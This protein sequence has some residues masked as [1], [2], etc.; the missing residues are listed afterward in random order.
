MGF[1]EITAR[2]FPGKRLDPK[3]EGIKATV[4]IGVLD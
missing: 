1:P 2:G 3:R 4:F